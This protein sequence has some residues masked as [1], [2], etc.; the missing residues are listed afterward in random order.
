MRDTRAV[1]KVANLTATCP[2][3]TRER[4]QTTRSFAHFPECG[5]CRNREVC[6]HNC[7]FTQRQHNR[8]RAEASSS[9]RHKTGSMAWVLFPPHAYLHEAHEC[10]VG[11]CWKLPKPARTI[12]PIKGIIQS[13][14]QHHPFKHPC[15]SS[16]QPQPANQKRPAIPPTAPL[17]QTCLILHAQRRPAKPLRPR[18]THAWRALTFIICFQPFDRCASRIAAQV[19]GFEAQKR[20]A[21]HRP[22]PKGVYAAN[23]TA[24][25]PKGQQAQPRMSGLS[26]QSANHYNGNLRIICYV[27]L[28]LLLKLL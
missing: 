8:A 2:T 6:A 12:G 10:G 9:H 21:R 28:L 26:P 7:I 15:Q 4:P 27:L 16:N 14:M 3:Q 17:S 18:L 11:A 19:Q 23:H 1:G 20:A 13:N 22:H 5:G 24:S 25:G